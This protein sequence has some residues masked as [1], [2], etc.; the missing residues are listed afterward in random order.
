MHGGILK[1]AADL[2]HIQAGKRI[3]SAPFHLVSR[4]A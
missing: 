1:Q 4:Y 2:S 3:A